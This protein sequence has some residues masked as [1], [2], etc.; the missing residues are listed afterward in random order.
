MNPKH[1]FRYALLVFL[2]GA[3]GTARAQD[4]DAEEEA[5]K[6]DWK[7]TAE[8]GGVWTQGN[9]ESNTTALALTAT[10]AWVKSDVK[11]Q[12]GGTRTRSAV[13][14]RMAEGTTSSYTVTEEK[15][16]ETTADLYYA[17]GLYNYNVTKKFFL[18][19]GADW[20]RNVP[21][22]TDSR[23]LIALGGGN[24]W[25]DSDK[26]TFSTRYSFTYTFEQDVVENPLT[27]SNFPGLRLAYGL[28]Y[29]VSSTTDFTSEGTA[30]WNLDNTDDV[31]VE[32]LNSIAVSISKALALKFGQQLYWRN[33]PALTDVPLFTGGSDTG[34]VVR[35]P[36][37]ELDNV[38]TVSLMVKI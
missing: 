4:T 35:V 15:T 6:Y 33:D 7:F 3:A 18:Y 16:Y 20:L 27:E 1:M 28:D 37:K 12:A 21:A 17:R 26:V 38:F 11:L 10:K 22:G 30:D 9:S 5:K 24:H 31:R 29:T 14:T 34:E 25:A 13:I 2:L 8:L 19:G 32:W 36:L 23:F